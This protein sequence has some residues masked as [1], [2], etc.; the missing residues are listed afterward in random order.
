MAAA[1][2]DRLWRES[3]PDAVDRDLATLWRD[4]GREGPIA[5]ALMANLVVF[6]ESAPDV[7][8]DLSSPLP[9]VPVDEV[10]GRHPSRV[11]VLRHSRGRADPCAPVAASVGVLT[12][13]PPQSRYGVE[14]IAVRSACATASLPSIVRRM[15]LGYV[16]TSVWW[17]DDLSEVTPLE[18]LVVMGRQLLYDSRRWRDVRRA[19]RRLAALLGASH[20][21]DLADL[22]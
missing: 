9:D 19:V 22:N 18:P 13:G 17:T 6:R 3:S 4:V 16:P 2:I 5:R 20:S 21:L 12:F 10:S 8:T 15:T 14:H 1:L 11:I 7:E